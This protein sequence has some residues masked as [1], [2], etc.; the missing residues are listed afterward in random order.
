VARLAEVSGVDIVDY[1]SFSRALE[2]Q[3][4]RFKSLGATATDHSCV[5]PN[6]ARLSPAEACAIFDR[7]LRGRPTA[8]TPP[9]SRP[10]C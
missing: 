2:A 5:A 4:A 3:R 6:A 7:V 10:T 1:A 9:A 8:P